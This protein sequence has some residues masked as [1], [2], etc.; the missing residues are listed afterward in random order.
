MATHPAQ[1]LTDGVWYLPAA[2][3]TFIIR[4]EDD[5]S[6]LVD[7]GQ[8]KDYARRLL[9]ASR[10]LGLE[11]A[12]IINT[13]AHSDHFGGNSWLH[14]RLPDARILAP[15]G[16]ATVI[17]EPALQP[18]GLFHGAQPLPELLQKWTHGQPSE[19]HGE[20]NEGRLSLLGVELELI[21]A[22]GHAREQLAV[23]AGD[24]LIA[25]DGLF[26]ADLLEKYPLPFSHDPGQ[27]QESVRRLAALPV[28]LAAP[29]H[30]SPA[31]VSELARLN[32]AAIERVTAALLEALDTPA[33]LGTILK[34]LAD[35][36]DIHMTDP[37]RYLLNFSTVAAWL[38]WLR[39]EQ[40]V[41]C[42]VEGNSMLW[43]RRQLPYGEPGA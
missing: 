25:A 34:R 33:E 31:P 16:A 8:D 22:P 24:V 40:V 18:L 26:G 29:G 20:L 39:T 19:V 5:R 4:A 42:T 15:A 30:G 23:I 27:Q 7:T 17:R 36:L 35:A 13:H 32:L 21:D 11:P 3:N 38:G 14:K 43:R 2:V 37:V 12:A 28:R 41:E 10:E 6:I 1:E 9:K